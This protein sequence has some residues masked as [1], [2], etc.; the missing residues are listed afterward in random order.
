LNQPCAVWIPVPLNAVTRALCFFKTEGSYAASE[1]ITVHAG[2]TK[3]TVLK[4]KY[5]TKTCVE[6]KIQTIITHPKPTRSPA[7]RVRVGKEE[8]NPLRRVFR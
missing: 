7:Q 5:V 1:T 6:K 4:E 8:R 3:Q 2:S